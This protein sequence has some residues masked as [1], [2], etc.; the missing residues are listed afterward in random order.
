[1]DSYRD[2]VATLHRRIF[3]YG[4]DDGVFGGFKSSIDVYPTPDRGITTVDFASENKC[5]PLCSSR[6]GSMAVH[7]AFAFIGC[8]RFVKL[9]YGMGNADGGLHKIFDNLSK[10]T[11]QCFERAET[12][13]L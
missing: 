3:F 6:T 11:R 10:K 13:F 9:R 2:K 1:M 8:E 5:S 12:H 7:P 4:D